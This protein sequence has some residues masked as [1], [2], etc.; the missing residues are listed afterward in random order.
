M[1]VVPLQ[2]LEVNMQPL[3]LQEVDLTHQPEEQ[4]KEVLPELSQRP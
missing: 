4:T 2:F 3:H 1:I